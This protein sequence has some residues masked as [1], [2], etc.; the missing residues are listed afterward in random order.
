MSVKA[1]G[2]LFDGKLETPLAG[3]LSE[4]MHGQLK[5]VI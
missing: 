3:Q 4:L 5:T 1:A 2:W